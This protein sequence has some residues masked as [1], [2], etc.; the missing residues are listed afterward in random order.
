MMG[1][2]AKDVFWL[3]LLLLCAVVA[4]ILYNSWS[5]CHGRC[6][7]QTFCTLGWSGLWLLGIIGLA[8]SVLLGV[9]LYNVLKQ[10]RGLCACGRH[11]DDGG[12][13]CPD[14]GKGNTL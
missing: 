8:L 2:S 3:R 4:V 1:F 5:Y 11:L 10:R 7:I 6:S 9:R 14:C 13:F 12:A